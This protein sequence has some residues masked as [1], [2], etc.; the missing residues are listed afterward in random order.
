MAEHPTFVEERRAICA[1]CPEKNP[2]GMC[3]QCGCVIYI[4]TML[5]A[6]ECPLQ[7]W[8]QQPK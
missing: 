1:A 8:G 7:R 6:S 3:N 2:I 5:R 4:K